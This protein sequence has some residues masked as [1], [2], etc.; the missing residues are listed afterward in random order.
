MESSL[1]GS[2]HFA[3]QELASGVHAAVARDGGWA[4]SNAGIVDLGDAT[5]VFDTLF[6]QEA[7]TDL[8]DA[9]KRLTGRQAEYVVTSH[10]HDDHLVGNQVFPHVK[11]VST[12]K[13]RE[14]ILTKTQREF[15]EDRDNAAKL[16]EDLRSG[17]LPL[18]DSEKGLY[19]GWMQAILESA[20]TFQLIASNLTFDS[21]FVIHGSR[22][23][24]HILTYG[25]GHTAS[26]A[27]LFLPD[28]RIAFLGDLLFIDFHPWLADGD[29]GEL[30]RIL[31]RIE[32]L[33][34]ETAVPG[35][36]PVGTARDLGVIRRYVIELERLAGEVR[37]SGGTKEQASQT[38]VP[39]DFAGWKFSRFY[40]QNMAFL[41]D[42]LEP[43]RR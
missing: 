7:G 34:V 35:H 17:K 39:S 42:W 29:P 30:V 13:T 20:P 11:I 43:A 27:F 5:L 4:V 28:E 26:D 25:G 2:R 19:E 21:E 40:P 36:G 22:R 37:K 9:A 32:K 10:Y 33:K 8:R 3:L 12:A 1:P 15:Q 24:V 6:S 16:F 38:P 18:P 14:L 31:E 23:T 41:F